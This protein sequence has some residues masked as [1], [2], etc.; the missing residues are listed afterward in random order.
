[1]AIGDVIERRPQ[2]A[3][4]VILQRDEAEGLEYALCR[5]THGREKLCHPVYRSGL[6]LKRNFNEVALRQFT[7]Q[8]Q[9]SASD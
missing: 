1:M 7:R 9:Q 5:L 8:F 3:V 6:G 4:V 2:P